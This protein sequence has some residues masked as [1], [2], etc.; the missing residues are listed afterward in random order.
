VL[1]RGAKVVARSA[2]KLPQQE[3]G[4]LADVLPALSEQV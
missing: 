2:A 3:K 1:H 4:N